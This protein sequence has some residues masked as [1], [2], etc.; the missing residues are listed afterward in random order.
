M[1][2][3]APRV[4]K[5]LARCGLCSRRE[6]ERFI[7]AGRVRV[8]GELISSPALDIVP[9]DVLELDRQRINHVMLARQ[10]PRLWAAHKLRDELVTRSDPAARRT[11]FDRFKQMGVS[12]VRVLESYSLAPRD[13]RSVQT[14]GRLGGVA[15]YVRYTNDDV[16]RRDPASVSTERRRH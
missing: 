9:T 5:L 2:T 1:A 4:A 8:N 3:S 15:L 6:G 10:P 12:E 16:T 13:D 14:D 7:L 11:I